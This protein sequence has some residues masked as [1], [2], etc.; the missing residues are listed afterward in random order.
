MAYRRT[1]PQTSYSS[2]ASSP[3]PRP[4]HK[5]PRRSPP[6]HL[7]R[8]K[9]TASAEVSERALSEDRPALVPVQPNLRR[10]PTRALQLSRTDE[11]MRAPNDSDSCPRAGSKR[12]RVASANENVASTSARNP[13]RG[14]SRIKR[15]RSESGRRVNGD[16]DSDSE[17][18]TMKI[19]HGSASD[20]PSELTEEE[21]GVDSDE[22]SA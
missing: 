4:K 20:D 6:A 3:T 1:S 15:L 7:P 17:S 18:D 5:L 21:E 10:L 13:A 12:K 2:A 9:R 14:A 8:H 11:D 19:D 16:G 22:N